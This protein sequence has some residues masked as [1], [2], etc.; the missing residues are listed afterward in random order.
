MLAV[1]ILNGTR[2]GIRTPDLLVRSQTLYPAGLYA[3]IC[4]TSIL[5]ALKNFYQQNF[6]RYPQT[7]AIPE[8]FAKKM[9]L[10]AA[11]ILNNLGR[12]FGDLCYTGML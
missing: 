10:L 4:L 5:Y 12:R 7:P 2:R 1:F 11:N 3:Q 8:K 9:L 6:V